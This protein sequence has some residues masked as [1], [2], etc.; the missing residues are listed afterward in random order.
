MGLTAKKVYA[1]LNGKIE[2]L[3]GDV[4]DLGT[5][6]F[7]AGSISTADLL[8][9][10]PKLG[11]VYNI[12]QKSIYG[13]SGTNVA[14]NGVLW[15][16]LG[17]TFDLSLLLT[18]ENAKNLYLQKNQ[19]LE[20][21]GKFL[22]VGED[23]NVIPS[24]TQT[25]DV[26][27]DTT[28][29]KPGE[30]A[31]SKATGDELKKKATQEDV[32][33]LNEGYKSL[34]SIVAIKSPN[35]FDTSKILNKS[36]RD[37]GTVID[38]PGSIAL[39]NVPIKQGESVV[40]KGFSNR[41]DMWYGY[42]YDAARKLIG[43]FGL[44]NFDSTYNGTASWGSYGNKYTAIE[45]ASYISLVVNKSTYDLGENY[46]LEYGDNLSKYTPYG[47]LL[48][49]YEDEILSITKKQD[50]LKAGKGI[51]IDE[52]NVISCI[53]E[54]GSEDTG[55]SYEHESKIINNSYSVLPEIANPSELLFA[56]NN[57]INENARFLF[58][59]HKILA[60]NNYFI[61]SS[62]KSA[63]KTSKS[64]ALEI[65]FEYDGI[66]FE[67][68]S[69]G[70]A[71]F[72]FKV[73]E[74]DGWKY[75]D[76]KP[77]HV[78]TQNGY[79][80]YTQIRFNSEK[81]RKI[82]IETSNTVW[83]LRYDAEYQVSPL[84]LIKPLSLFA[85]SSITEGS[86]ANE[87]PM[88]SYGNVCSNE[89]GWEFINLGVGARGMITSTDTKPSIA[90]AITDITQFK[91]AK[92]IFLGGSI[93]DSG[94]AKAPEDY[95]N[96]VNGLIDSIKSS[97]PNSTIIILGTWSPQPD[98]G[99]ATHRTINNLLKE[100]A[101]LKKCAFIDSINSMV[102]DADGNIVQKGTPWVT[103]VFSH[104]TGDDEMSKIGNCARI[105][106]HESGSIDHIHPG[107]IGH[108][109]IG[110]RLASACRVLGF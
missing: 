87:F 7:Y 2:K 10:S 74:G 108:K 18:N 58:G 51:N 40:F 48:F 6:L 64:G 56:E 104:A 32:G 52:S 30:A 62:D 25:V 105:Y 93:N 55:I 5:P 27:I 94:Y 39:L 77:L 8:P 46:Q 28:L 15:D 89:L 67:I 21:S 66:A 13:E 107:R 106:K 3:S 81:H 20:N 34:E 65:S 57:V 70:L 99:N 63:T 23:G 92:Y 43:R 42:V 109:Y 101:H 24:N 83:C 100:C 26:K 68:G 44:V 72:R 14:W 79:R 61:I 36:I 47:T 86:A 35:I 50:K 84:T 85:G 102:Y 29:T 110:M 31:D 12:E 69:R 95:K 97:L 37:D 22:A 91:N 98:S 76:E 45:N 16:A 80:T 88:A 59:S 19:G 17:S 73:D 38:N 1:I 54:S 49:K 71:D 82:I 103:G 96:G 53:I 11:A 9:S 75:L 60:E 41:T 33:K 90:D 78:S 4:S